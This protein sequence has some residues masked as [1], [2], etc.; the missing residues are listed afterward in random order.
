MSSNVGQ[1]YPYTSETEA[2]RAAAVER[3]VGQFEG[4]AEKIK[5]EATPLGPDL[6]DDNVDGPRWWV[7]VCPEHDFTG[8]LHIAGYALE[9]HG[10]YT[11]CDTCGKAF[12]R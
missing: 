5:T 2:Q 4:L 12:L 3:A 9:R 11:V 6:G 10:V 8:R 7:W 1:N